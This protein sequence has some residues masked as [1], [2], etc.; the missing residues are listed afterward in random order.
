M[1]LNWREQVLT[2]NRGGDT[3]GDMVGLLP[4]YTVGSGG[5]VTAGTHTSGVKAVNR[6]QGTS[7]PPHT[8]ENKAEAGDQQYDAAHGG[9]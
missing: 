6:R 3:N 8:D 7:S 1:L 2:S 4:G 9:E 5:Y